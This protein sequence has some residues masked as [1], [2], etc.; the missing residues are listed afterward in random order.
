MTDPEPLRARAK[1]LF[2]DAEQALNADPEVGREPLR[3][4]EEHR[5]TLEGLQYHVVVCG[6]YKRGKSSLLNALIGRP[7]LFPVDVHVATNTVSTLEYGTEERAT[8]YL[9]PEAEGEE[10][11]AVDVPLAEL[12]DYVTEQKNEQNVRNVRLVRIQLPL[13]QLRTGL[14]MVDTPGVGS[15]NLAHDAATHAFLGQA[16]AL[17]FVGDLVVTFSTDELAFLE[18]ALAKCPTVITVLTRSDQ[19]VDPDPSLRAARRKIADVTGRAE[20]DLVVLP[21]SSPLRASAWQSGDAEMLA[22]SGFPDLEKE[23]WDGLVTRVGRQRVARCA[24]GLADALAVARAPIDLA[25]ESRSD[26]EIERF[27]QELARRAE[28]AADLQA[29]SAHWRT[30]LPRVFHDETRRI[31]Q[32]LQGIFEAACQDFSATAAMVTDPG[33][34]D[35]TVREIGRLLVDGVEVAMDQLRSAARQVQQAFAAQTQVPY[36]PASFSVGGF[37]PA[38]HGVTASPPELDAGSGQPAHHLSNTW[39]S[40]IAGA[41]LGGVI[42]GMI[43]VVGGPPG[44]AVGAALGGL[45]GKV[46]GAIT[47]WSDSRRAERE[48]AEQQRKEWSR[49]AVRALTSGTLAQ[50]RANE[51]RGL[52]AFDDAAREISRLLVADIERGIEEARESL[53][54][55]RREVEEE[56]RRS[57]AEQRAR[58]AELTERRDGYTR[59]IES[60]QELADLAG[61]P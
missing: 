13:D 39:R 4:L 61:G 11:T 21:V 59:L 7:G 38:L 50:I 15:M 26:A 33:Q 16:D 14:V 34:L 17:I 35:G 37:T 25:L 10:L 43:G 48:R 8:A 53:E 9:A 18:R 28:L 2:T 24:V 27:D 49:E 42:G 12:R 36:Q 40:A 29:R 55:S 54:R 56:R 44:I 46:V 57:E 58:R 3:R 22:D 41:G 19:V 51:A 23:L 47:G 32:G 52:A 45:L 30:E 31:K 20:A 1:T 5:A 60:A 6:E